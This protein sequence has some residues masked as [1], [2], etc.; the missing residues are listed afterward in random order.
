MTT[1]HPGVG[2]GGHRHPGGG[3]RAEEGLGRQ[4]DRM[5]GLSLS[6]FPS[7]PERGTRP[8]WGDG[9]LGRSD[10]TS[11]RGRGIAH[12]CQT[13]GK[14]SPPSTRVSP[15]PRSPKVWVQTHYNRTSESRGGLV[16]GLV[17]GAGRRG[18]PTDM[19][20]A[21]TS[22][23]FLLGVGEEVRESTRLPRVP[24]S[25]PRTPWVPRPVLPQSGDFPR[26]F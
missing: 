3:G 26:R 18:P 24:H 14:M 5:S 17:G 22:L 13:R 19:G 4:D 12:P 7:R 20:F 2:V 11:T 23:L 6:V 1:V 9:S 15:V 25:P 16:R 21:P 8:S 10:L